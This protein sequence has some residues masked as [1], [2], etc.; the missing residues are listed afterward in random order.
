MRAKRTSMNADRMFELAD[1]LAI[2]KSRQD[3][4]TAVRLLHPDMILDVPAFGTLARGTA[5][6][7]KV[8]NRFFMSFPDYRVDL[9]GHASDGRVLICWGRL[10]MTMTG[11]R[12]GVVPNG[13]CAR[14]SAF[15]EFSFEDDL[16]AS[17]RFFFDLS[18]LCAQSGVST[19]AVRTK[20]FGGGPV[21]DVEAILSTTGQQ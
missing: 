1:A 20:L 7:E 3:V 17:E 21:P 11:D 10:R 9:D 5:E 14:L 8:L 13:V 15:I 12:F 4:P 2:A 19:D 18:E 16:I 6:N